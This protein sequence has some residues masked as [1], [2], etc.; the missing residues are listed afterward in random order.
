MYKNLQI[1]TNLYLL[2]FGINFFFFLV[3]K[4]NLILYIYSKT[5]TMYELVQFAKFVQ[6]YNTKVSV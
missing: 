5:L 6:F 1:T 2:I 4:D 3:L